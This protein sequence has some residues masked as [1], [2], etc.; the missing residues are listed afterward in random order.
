MNIPAGLK[1]IPETTNE[2]Q[3]EFPENKD[4]KAQTV[5]V[6]CAYLCAFPVLN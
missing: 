4:N 3:L 1:K 5:S 2:K 6:L